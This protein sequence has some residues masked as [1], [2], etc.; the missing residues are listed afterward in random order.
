MPPQPVEWHR[1]GHRAELIDLVLEFVQGVRGMEGVTDIS[2]IGSLCA[3]KPYPKDADLLVT[4]EAE[5]D[6]TGLA[7]HSRRLQGRAQGIGHGSDVFLL[8]PTGE[9]IGRVCPWK[10][11]R[12]G[13]RLSCDAEHCG[14]REYLHDDLRTVR[15]A[16]TVTANPP[17]RLWPC[18]E[19]HGD[20]PADIVARLI[21]PLRKHSQE[22]GEPAT[23][24]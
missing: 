15:L 17:L 8:N 11:C 19:E 18:I 22:L 21:A 16:G 3:P 14:R 23:E 13:I 10:E 7:R 6:L 2:L 24:P 20:L 12:P 4:V 9:Y 1:F 5:A